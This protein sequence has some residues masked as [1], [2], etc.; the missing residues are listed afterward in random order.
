MT[1]TTPR[2][3]ADPLTRRRRR[4]RVAGVLAAHSVRRA[5][6]PP[7]ADDRRRRVCGAADVLVALGVRVRVVPS[8]EPWP[9]SGRLVVSDSTGWL[10]D[11]AVI[12]AVAGAPVENA[13]TAPR[14]A[15]PG[16]TLCPVSVR[17]RLDGEPHHLDDDRI[18]RT[19]AQVIALQGL[20]VEV[21]CRPALTC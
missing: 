20:V 21:H 18:P 19:R 11:L 3:V 10:G 7:G 5:L 2:P 12:T 14:V 8:P 13:T 9:R 17:Y 15:P 4:V 16:T 6:R 1:S